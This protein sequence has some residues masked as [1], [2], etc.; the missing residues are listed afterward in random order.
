MYHSGDEVSFFRTLVI[1]F[2]SSLYSGSY[3]C[4]DT[5]NLNMFKDRNPQACLTK[6]CYAGCH[7]RWRGLESHLLKGAYIFIHICFQAT[8]ISIL[9]LHMLEFNSITL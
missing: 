3:R 8:F 7:T 4:M 5:G 1:A 9:T 6:G 2:L